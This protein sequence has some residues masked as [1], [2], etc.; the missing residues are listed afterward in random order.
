MCVCDSLPV[1]S[2]V[3][4]RVG[5]PARLV[6]QSV[7]LWNQTHSDGSPHTGVHDGHLHSQK[8]NSSS[9]SSRVKQREVCVLAETHHTHTHTRARYSHCEGVLG[10]QCEQL[11]RVYQGVDQRLPSGTDRK[12]KCLTE[13]DLLRV[14]GRTDL[15]ERDGL[16]QQGTARRAEL[17]SARTLSEIPQDCQG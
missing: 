13:T 7:E 2:V 9:T 17:T 12:I 1:V 15:R 11:Y 5:Q 3:R 6:V 4:H 16:G 10:L 8:S 14:R